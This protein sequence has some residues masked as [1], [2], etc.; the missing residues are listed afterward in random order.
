MKTLQKYTNM[1]FLLISVATIVPA[2]AN[3]AD[4]LT[5]KYIALKERMIQQST[6][7]DI[8]KKVFQVSEATFQFALQA[9]SAMAILTFMSVAFRGHAKAK[10]AGAQRDKNASLF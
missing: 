3:L 1:A 2:N 4:E 10:V 6:R 5:D 9:A 8:F 7:P